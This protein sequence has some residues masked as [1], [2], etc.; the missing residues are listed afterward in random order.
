[1]RSDT[2]IWREAT[3][4]S[5]ETRDPYHAWILDGDLTDEAY[6][7]MARSFPAHLARPYP[8]PGGLKWNCNRTH[9]EL[10]EFIESNHD[11]S[12]F[13]HG[14]AERFATPDSYSDYKFEFSFLPPGGGLRPHTDTKR[15]FQTG[16]FYFPPVDGWVPTWGGDFEVLRHQEPE[17]RFHQ[18][19]LPPWE[20]VSTVKSVDYIPNRAVFME[21]SDRSLHGVRP[22]SQPEGIF[23]QTVTVAWLKK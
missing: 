20:E 3:K 23:R 4:P 18:K 2:S 6:L 14:V 5:W 1:M 10:M 8:Y 21:R 11:W 17:R 16:V 9:P 12:E 13:F 22:T 19:D 15:K 7:R